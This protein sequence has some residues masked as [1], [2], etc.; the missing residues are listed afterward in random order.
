MTEGKKLLEEFL[1][2]ACGYGYDCEGFL[3][4]DR[5]VLINSLD[6]FIP[7]EILV[8]EIVEPLLEVKRFVKI[9]KSKFKDC[10][11]L[12][13]LTKIDRTIEDFIVE[14]SID[15][16]LTFPVLPSQFIRSLFLLKQF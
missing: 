12:I 1:N 11:I 9:I 7:I 5:E 2:C 6:N 8:L 3:W 14:Y 10:K 16:Y 15:A 4:D 13:L